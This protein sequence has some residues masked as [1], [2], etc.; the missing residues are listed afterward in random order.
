MTTEQGIRNKIKIFRLKSQKVNLFSPNLNDKSIRL[1]KL[2]DDQNNRF[3]ILVFTSS[4][5]LEIPLTTSLNFSI[6]IPDKV[7]L[8][9]KIL[10]EINGIGKIYTNNSKNNQIINCIEL[11][12]DALKT[13]DL[14]SN[15]GLTVYRNSL[16]LTLKQNRKLL[17][18][19]EICKKIKTII[20]LNFPDI[21]NRTEYYD[22]PDDLKQ[23]L[24]KFE[25]FAITDDFER[26]ELIE[27]LTTIQRKDLIKVIGSKLEAIDLFL[28]T[29]GDNPLTEGAIGLQ[30]L[31]ELTT[32]LTNDEKKNHS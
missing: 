2:K 16:Q 7:C 25:N 12:K 29:F 5:T 27:G 22:L 21:V 1:F 10:K 17:S 6:N 26:N 14:D 13:L 28:N 19:I 31:A 18:E 24:L 15:E 11:L 23:I 20:E 4:L 32:Q 30:C 3:K 8:A 9:D